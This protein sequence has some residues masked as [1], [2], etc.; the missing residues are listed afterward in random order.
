M[1]DKRQAQFLAEFDELIQARLI[2]LATIRKDG[3][4]SNA[5]PL[6]FTNTP[7]RTILIQ[8]GPE[9]W[10]TRRIKGGSPVIVWIGRQR[11]L[12]L[13]G[14]AELSADPLI[15]ER[16]I[17]DYPRK[18]LMARLGL[19]RPS[20]LSFARGERL[21]IKITPLEVLPSGFRSQP[22]VPVPNITT[23]KIGS[24]GFR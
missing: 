6:W 21:A 20:K 14:R 13:V 3:T 4:Q 5:A 17:K 22:G 2:Y 7:D 9:S 11:N 24:A 23:A 10:H 8:S 15:I 16:I 1:K 12:A 19:H 18:Y